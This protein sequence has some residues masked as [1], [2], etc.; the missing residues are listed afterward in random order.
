MGPPRSTTALALAISVATMVVALA[1]AELAFRGS[2]AHHAFIFEARHAILAYTYPR[3]E[4]ESDIVAIGDSRVIHGFHPPTIEALIAQRTGTH[5][6]V[7]NL[8]LAGAP[9]T[10][11]LAWTSYLLQ[12]EK[13]PSLV[14]FYVSPYMFSDAQNKSYAKEIVD[15]VFQSNDAWVAWRA[16]MPLEEAMTIVWNNL[17]STLRFRR[18]ILT[19]LREDEALKPAINLGDHGFQPAGRTWSQ[20]QQRLAQARSQATREVLDPDADIWA[21]QFQF[22]RTAIRRLQDAG[23]TVIITTPPTASSIW[24]YLSLIH[25]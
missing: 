21:A 12:Q 19:W 1:S 24:R 9:A 25:I 10:G 7:H 17:A 16:G 11:H 14:I 5:R 13:P 6:A 18:R 2:T 3:L 23:I 15:H 22:L 8:G 4:R 20:T